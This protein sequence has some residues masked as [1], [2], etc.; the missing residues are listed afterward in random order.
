VEAVAVELLIEVILAELAVVLIVELA[1]PAVVG[2]LAVEVLTVAMVEPDSL[3]LLVVVTAVVLTT[4][5]DA[6]EP[7]AMVEAEVVELL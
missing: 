2:V 4:V 5:V 1:P 6:V 7:P 3:E